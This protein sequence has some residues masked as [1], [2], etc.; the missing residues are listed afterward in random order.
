VTAVRVHRRRVPDV[1]ESAPIR[2]RRTRPS[3]V[4]EEAPETPIKARITR[5]RPA[6][7]E[8][9]VRRVRRGARAQGIDEYKQHALP[10][11]RPL[12]II[13]WT[14]P[15]SWQFSIYMVT[16]FLYYHMNRSMITDHD[17]DRLCKNLDEGF[18]DFAHIHKHLVD[19]GQFVAGTG[20][21]IKDYPLMVKGAAAHMLDHYRER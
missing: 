17:F 7:Q 16:S 21:A 6:P 3:V 10:D 20:Y 9:Q 11:S 8:Q 2:V 1:V 15:L 5:T 18:D 12:F 14:R 13:D 19:R 4:E